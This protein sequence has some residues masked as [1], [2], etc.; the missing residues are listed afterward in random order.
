M[1]WALLL[2]ET[3]PVARATAVPLIVPI[4]VSMAVAMALP[5][6]V[7]FHEL[8][9]AFALIELSL[10]ESPIAVAVAVDAH[11]VLPP[12]PVAFALEDAE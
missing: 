9:V 3:A 6:T 11:G 7:P 8:A 12:P 4:E 2:P 10:A 5:P 1:L